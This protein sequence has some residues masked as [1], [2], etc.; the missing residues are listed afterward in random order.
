[1]LNPF[2]KLFGKRA[3]NR[4]DLPEEAPVGQQQA[5]ST[6]Y[7]AAVRVDVLPK[8]TRPA[9][10]AQPA[11]SLDTTISLPLRAVLG[12]LPADLMSRVRVVDVGEA[13]MFVPMQKVLAQLASG[14]VRISFGELRQASPPGTFS[15]ENDRDRALV[16]LPLH[17]ILSR[18]NPALLARRSAQRHIEVPAEV[19]G[20]FGGQTRLTISTTPAK[21]AAAARQVPTHAD[22]SFY[23]NQTPAPQAPEPPVYSPIAPAAPRSVQ[24]GP[25]PG[26][27]I[28]RRNNAPAAPSGPAGYTPISPI[29]PGPAPAPRTAPLPQMPGFN[30]VNQ[31]QPA[32]PARPASLPIPEQ[33]IFGRMPAAQPEQPAPEEPLALPEQPVFTR[34]GAPQY[35]PPPPVYAPIPP[36]PAVEE[37]PI[38]FP[39]QQD[40]PA[41]SFRD[42]AAQPPLSAPQPVAFPTPPPEPEPI[43]FNPSF[44][45][46][47]QTRATPAPAPAAPAPAPAPAATR[48]SIFLTVPVADLA[49]TWPEPIKHEIVALNLGSAATALPQGVI[50]TAIKQGRVIFPWKL[51]RS[52][53]KPAVSPAHVSANDAMLIELSLKVVTPAFLA[54][55]RGVRT[56]KKVSIDANIPNLFSGT[57]AIPEAAVAPPAAPAPVRPAAPVA[58]A[59]AP[60]APPAAPDTNY[61]VWKDGTASTEEEPPPVV[62]KGPSPGT[63]FLQR[64]ATPNEIVSKAAALNGVGGALI[65]LPDGLLVASKIP[66][67]FNA[68]TL[69]AFLPQI[70]ARV[71]QTTRELRMGELN[72]LNFTVGLIPWKIFRV[73]AIYFAAFGIAG[74][75]L[76]TAQLAGIAAELDRKAK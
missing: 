63:S 44:A 37:A 59:P 55:L 13:E 28:F 57:T 10:Q 6:S 22:T 75:G 52:W 43:R 66:S 29:S 15:P 1:M 68:D 40:I 41:P 18:V 5:R 64:Y 32:Q 20:P 14:S 49:Q 31:A 38:P 17:E 27:P 21:P 11:Q 9:P 56:Q 47:P 3:E 65:A 12:R 69:A 4:S 39:E 70:F 67:D 76:P 73:G 61:Y 8:T 16:E 35:S 46:P 36:E 30:R 72:N 25:A 26:Q 54:S 62:K 24:P 74:Q 2:R 50:E 71:S 53:I 48:E 34:A 19:T 7:S 51:I 42:V 60:V 58:A 33:P 23:R 45:P